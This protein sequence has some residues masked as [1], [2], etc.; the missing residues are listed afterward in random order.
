M[1]WVVALSTT[2]V[3]INN[4]NFQIVLVFCLKNQKKGSIDDK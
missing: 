4:T 3:Q 1:F 2:L